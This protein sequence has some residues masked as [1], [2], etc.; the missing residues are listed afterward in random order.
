MS[1]TET[2]VIFLRWAVGDAKQSSRKF[3]FLCCTSQERVNEE[4]LRKV[5]PRISPRRELVVLNTYRQWPYP[6]CTSDKH[7]REAPEN[8]G[9]PTRSTWSDLPP[10]VGSGERGQRG[11]SRGTPGHKYGTASRCQVHT[12]LQSLY[13]IIVPS[14][15]ESSH[16]SSSAFARHKDN[17]RAIFVYW[18]FVLGGF[19]NVLWSK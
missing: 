12:C 14:A 19:V 11:T 15:L 7:L 9:I 16:C 17:N 3:V 13:L 10:D 18:F 8:D 2:L 6:R 4:S 1:N 5:N